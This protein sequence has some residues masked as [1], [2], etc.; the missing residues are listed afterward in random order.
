MRLDTSD[1]EE[2]KRL[3]ESL[4]RRE[5]RCD[6]DYMRS[7][8]SPELFEFGRSG[9]T[10]TRDQLLD[11]PDQPIRATLPLRNFT[12]HLVAEDVALVTYVSEVQDDTTELGNRSS[13]WVRHDGRWRLRFH[14]GTVTGSS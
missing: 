1:L 2:L 3:E 14:Q 8:T 7:I 10:Y 11:V 13:L 9:Q 4:W 5:T 12:V 6:P